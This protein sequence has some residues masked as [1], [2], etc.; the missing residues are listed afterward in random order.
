M[1]T[2]SAETLKQDINREQVRDQRG[3]VDIKGLLQGL[4][5]SC[6]AIPRFP[7]MA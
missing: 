1:P 4:R 6:D 7:A 3:G 2:K 5:A